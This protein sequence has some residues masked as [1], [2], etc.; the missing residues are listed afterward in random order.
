MRTRTGSRVF[1]S[2]AMT[3]ALAAPVA[4]FAGGRVGIQGGAALFAGG[5]EVDSGGEKI[6]AETPNG[7]AFAVD[8]GWRATD[9]LEIGGLV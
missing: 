5:V 3:F 2:L 9:S 6:A 8:G 1:L 7:A 4:A